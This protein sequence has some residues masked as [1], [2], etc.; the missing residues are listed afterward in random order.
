M[1]W[2]GRAGQC[3]LA[4]VRSLWLALS[5]HRAMLLHRQGQPALDMVSDCFMVPLTREQVR[6]KGCDHMFVALKA[7]NWSGSCSEHIIWITLIDK[8]VDVVV[9]L[10]CSKWWFT[11]VTCS[12]MVHLLSSCQQSAHMP[13]NQAHKIPTLLRHLPKEV[14]LLA[15]RSSNYPCIQAVMGLNLS[16]VVHYNL[17]N[18]LQTFLGFSLKFECHMVTTDSP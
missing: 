3:Q 4:N 1:A 10:W 13:C 16:Q 14:H 12:P 15:D 6:G 9:S 18:S 17:H 7:Y 11:D 2:E 8:V 5:R